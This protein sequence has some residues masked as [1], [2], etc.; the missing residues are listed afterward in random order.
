[1]SFSNQFLRTLWSSPP[2]LFMPCSLETNTWPIHVFRENFWR[3][4]HFWDMSR[5]DVQVKICPAR[6]PSVVD[7][8][9]SRSLISWGLQNSHINILTLL[10]SV[11]F[12]TTFCKILF[13]KYCWHYL[14]TSV[15]LPFH[16]TTQEIS[17][18]LE[19]LVLSPINFIHRDIY[20]PGRFYL[21]VQEIQVRQRMSCWL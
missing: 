13:Q 12:I 6:N 10:D 9:I 20:P 16:K 15:D 21:T 3:F 7:I 1:M 4:I 19:V 11:S 8:K 17:H 2:D 5:K 18:V 14:M